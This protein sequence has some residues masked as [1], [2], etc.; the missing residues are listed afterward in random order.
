MLVQT[1]RRIERARGCL[2]DAGFATGRSGGFT[3]I[4]LLVV[5]AIIGILAGVVVGQYQR[6]IRKAKE[7]VLKENLFRT[8][9]AINQYFADKGRYPFDLQAL[10][11]DKYLRAMP[12]DPIT[13]S[14]ETW[15]VESAEL[16]DSDISLEPGISDLHSG[17]EGV[18]MDGTSFSEW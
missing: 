17:A 8:R 15:V 3:L 6:S 5:V 12:V 7:A 14:T 13:D 11:E 2:R 10:V 1:G 9:A 4:E 16:D 18:A